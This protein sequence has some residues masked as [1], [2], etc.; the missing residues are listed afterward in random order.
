MPKQEKDSEQSFAIAYIRLD[1]DA[2]DTT[3]ALLLKDI[4]TY[5]HWQRLRLI[6]TFTDRGYDGS[7]LARPGV[8]ELR[9]ALKETPGLTVVVPTLAHLSPAET[10][11]TALTQLISNLGGRLVVVCDVEAPN[12]VSI[13][14]QDAAG[15]EGVE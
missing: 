3:F 11:R 12:G 5:C 4:A 1:D 15:E 10:I 13:Y 7:Q 6:R 9:E 14:A 8:V 2:D